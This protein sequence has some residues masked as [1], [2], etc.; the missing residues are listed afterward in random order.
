[1]PLEDA[2][3][4]RSSETGDDQ[5]QILND[6]GEEI[7]TA[8]S[9]VV[10]AAHR[11]LSEAPAGISAMA[12]A[13]P[14]NMMVGEAKAEKNIGAINTE[15]RGNLRRLLLEPFVARVEVAWNP[16]GEQTVQTYYFPRRSAARLGAPS[17]THS[18]LPR[19]RRL[20]V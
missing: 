14:S 1:M 2:G 4:R 17:K 16:E 12:L 5:K 13:N 7:L 11:A 10:Q 15:N 8:L 3:S 18:S 20:D 6:V 19:E 9:T